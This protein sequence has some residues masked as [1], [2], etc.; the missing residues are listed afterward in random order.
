MFVAERVSAPTGVPALEASPGRVDE[1]LPREVCRLPDGSAPVVVHDGDANVCVHVCSSL[2]TTSSAVVAPDVPAEGVVDDAL[3]VAVPPDRCRVSEA[4]GGLACGGAESG[5]A[6]TSASSSGA[7]AEASP[8][9]IPSVGGG[10]VSR[11]ASTVGPFTSAVGPDGIAGSSSRLGSEASRVSEA[12]EEPLA[13]AVDSSSVV[14][15]S[16][17]EPA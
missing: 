5:A 4:A 8:V 1:V 10:G 12:R 3:A 14:R 6:V 16:C 11:L 2:P 9:V 17:T 13:A 7:G 15:G